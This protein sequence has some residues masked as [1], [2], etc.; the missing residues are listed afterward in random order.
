MESSLPQEI[1]DLGTIFGII[2]FFVTIWLLFEARKIRQSFLIKARLP[3]VIKELKNSS[4]LL[5]TH[6]K[7]WGQEE[8]KAIHQLHIS[9][10][11]IESLMPKLPDFAQKKC[12]IFVKS[13]TPFA[14]FTCFFKS[15]KIDEDQA[16]N[17][18]SLLSEVVTMLQQ[19]Q[20]DSKW[21]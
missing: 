12:K 14:L 21:D 3:E 1:I 16:W 20:K 15:S 17:L 5:S 4:S 13:I 9:K 11:L 6:L 19:L 7:N 8:K 2:G 10:A 18:Y